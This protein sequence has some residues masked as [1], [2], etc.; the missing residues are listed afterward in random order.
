MYEQ[1]SDLAEYLLDHYGE[2]SAKH[3]YCRKNNI[4]IGCDCPLWRP[5]GAR[6]WEE[7]REMMRFKYG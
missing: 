6:T 4:R 7:L 2:C 5:S 1:M 3:C